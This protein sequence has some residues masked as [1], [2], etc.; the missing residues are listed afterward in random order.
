MGYYSTLKTKEIPPFATTW[1]NLKV[2]M[3][4]EISDSQKH[5]HCNDYTYV[6]NLKYN[7]HRN[8]VEWWLLGAGGREKWR[9]TV[10]WVILVQ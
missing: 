3:Q 4:S 6:R 7:T 2:T 10:Q 8:N 5:K 1:K 9:V